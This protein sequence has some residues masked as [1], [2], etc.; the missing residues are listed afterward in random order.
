[1]LECKPRA[2]ASEQKLESNDKD[3]VDPKCYRE[4]VG[5]LIYATTCARP[6]ICWIMTKLSQYLSRPTKE[7]WIAVKHVLRYLKGTLDYALCYCKCADGLHLIEYINADWASS[8]DDRRNITGY[9][10]SL[11]KTGPLISWKSRKQRTVALSSC[12]AEYMALAAT[13]Q[14]GLHLAHLLNDIDETC[15]YETVM[16][17]GDNQGAIALTKNPMNHQRS[18]QID[19]RY[20]FIRTEVCSGRV[21]IE[22][23]PTTEMVADFDDKACD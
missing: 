16:I 19:V 3:P 12:E 2:T 20:H 22:F 8:T 1:M 5:S 10:F 13:V 21:V 23:C 4:A 6:D 15:Q 17:Y 9:C 11:T 7:H 14:E 18:K